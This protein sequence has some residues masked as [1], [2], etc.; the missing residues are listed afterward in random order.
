M[1]H[2]LKTFE[3]PLRLRNADTQIPRTYIYA[4]RTTP[5]D[6]FR[7]FADTAKREKWGYHEID[8]SHS[9]HVTAPEALMGL[10]QS[11]A[12]H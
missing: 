4:K 10:L 1:P 9:P 12:G 3:T 7:Q 5:E 2:P 8:A 11:V 6:T